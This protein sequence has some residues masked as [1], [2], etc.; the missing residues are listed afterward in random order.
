LVCPVCEAEQKLPG[1]WCTACGAYLGLLKRQPQRVVR[2]VCASIGL[3]LTLL[4]ALVWQVLTPLLQGW[5]TAAPGPLFWWGL[6]LGTFF[7]ALG[8]VAGSHLV[9]SWR[10]LL[11]SSTR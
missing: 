7:L 2:G 5:A 8:L 4:I 10:R 1:D 11:R 6:A 3:G 9:E